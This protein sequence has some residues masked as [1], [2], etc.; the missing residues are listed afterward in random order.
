MKIFSARDMIPHKIDIDQVWREREAEQ[1]KRNK[2]NF[3]K[4][5]PRDHHA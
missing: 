5:L 4:N 3:L 2:T 1:D